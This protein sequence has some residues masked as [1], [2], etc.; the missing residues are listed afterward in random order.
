MDLSGTDFMIVSQPYLMFLAGLAS[1]KGPY[2]QGQID[3]TCLGATM[4]LLCHLF[5]CMTRQKSMW[6]LYF[7]SSDK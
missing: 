2:W 5:Y 3:K 7:F 1:H 4:A 6:E